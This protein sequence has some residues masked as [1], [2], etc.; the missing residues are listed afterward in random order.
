MRVRAGLLDRQSRGR[1]E[2]TGKDRLGYLHGLLTNDVAVLSAGRGCY[3]A[4]L[5]PQGRMVTDMRVSELGDRVLIDLPAATADA[6][7]RRLADF[8]F[9]EDVEV[10]D[11]TATLTQF[12][13]YGPQA[14]VILARVT[15]GADREQLD[16]LAADANLQLAFNGVPLVVVRSSDYGLAGFELFAE[17][18]RGEDLA[19]ALR[20]AGASTVSLAT[21]DV[22]RIEAGRP[23]FGVDMDEHTIPLEAGL[24]DRAISQTKGCYVGQEVIIRVLHRGGGRVARHLVGLAAGSETDPMQPGERLK[25]EQRDI[26]VVTSA[27]FSP[28]LGRT[29][30]LGYVHR[31][32]MEPG[33]VLSVG[34]IGSRTA[35]VQAVPFTVPPTASR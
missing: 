8:I 33:T 22:T 27:A 35:T 6:V 11:V 14:T 30:G 19:N 18:A 24:L 16:S 9:A 20:T 23:E 28:A 13:L 3:A 32:F 5:T 17:S 2:L 26:G 15:A 31:D 7:R 25:S 29:I 10:H 21:A 34:P 12:G 4:L 1:L